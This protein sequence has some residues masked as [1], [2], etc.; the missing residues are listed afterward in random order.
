MSDDNEIVDLE[1]FAKAGR[2]VP[3]KA[4]RYRVK[5]DRE[6]HVVDGPCVLGREILALVDK[7][8]P[9]RFKL[10]Q[11]LRGGKPR[12]IAPDERVDFTEPGIER[13]RTIPC[14]QTE[15]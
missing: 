2:K 9:K 8:P 4:K 13:F 12:T 6:K 15:G 3:E 1:E 14:D 7:A 10:Q 5:V 11:L